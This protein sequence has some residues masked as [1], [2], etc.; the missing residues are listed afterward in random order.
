[1]LGGTGDKIVLLD[2]A[3]S[4]G[5]SAAEAGL[6]SMIPAL[7]AN[8]F[9]GNKMDPNLVAALMNG[10]NNQ[11]NFGGNGA[12]FL[13]IILLFGLFGRGFGG[14]GGNGAWAN[15]LPQQL[16]TDYGNQLLMNALGNNRSAI[17]QLASNLGCTTSALQNSLGQIQ[18]AISNV[19]GQA[20][21]NYQ[22][23]VNAIQSQGC[24]I[25]NQ[26]CQ[27]C[28]DTKSLI[29]QTS[30][31]TQSMVTNQGYEGRIETL[32]Q[33]NQL[34]N[35]INQGLA[36]NREAANAQFAILSQKMDAQSALLTA[37]FNGLEKRE[38]Q[39]KIDTLRDEKNALQASALTQQQTQNII[40]Q[41]RPCPVPSYPS[42]SPY[43]AYNWGAVFGNSC[44]CSN[45]CCCC[46]ANA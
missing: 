18:M 20:G 25:G 42:C 40:N 23:V 12:W 41:L 22:G 28:C 16:N 43:Q 4:N 21:M 7:F 6:Y 9:G 31:A 45:N 24:Q 35:T 3:G 26:I 44:G 1:M 11:D 14:W 38:L 2:G 19:A 34:Q 46:G 32:N 13:W 8:A 36:Q 30:C 27:C 10:R 39:N 29:N 37:Q 33:T 15:G 17:D 5:G